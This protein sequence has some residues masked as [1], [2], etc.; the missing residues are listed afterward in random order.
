MHETFLIGVDIGKFNH[1]AAVISSFGDLKVNSFSFTND[2]QGFNKFYET[3]KP[4]LS[5]D[6]LIG[7]E[8]TSHYADNFRLFLLIKKLSVA[9]IN[10]LSTDAFR[11]AA[12]KSTK[13]DKEDARFICQVLM[14]P[15][16]Y[17]RVTLSDYDYTEIRE[18]TRYHHNMQETNTRYKQKLQ[19]DLDLVFPEFNSLFSAPYGPTYM[20][21]LDNFQSAD[22]IAHTDIRRIR[23]AIQPKGSRGRSVSFS[24]EDLKSLAKNS[25]G[26]PN[27]IVEMEI[28]HLITLINDINTIIK[29]VDKKIEEFSIELNSPILSIPGISHFSG[30]SIISEFGDINRFP[31]VNKAI[32]FTGTN[33]IVYQSGGYNA[34]MTRISKKGSK[35]LRK[36]LYQVI[37]PVILNNQVFQDYYNKKRAEGKSHRCAQGHCVRKLVRVIYHLL[38]T[39]ENFDPTKLI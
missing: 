9:M 39:G 30:T 6:H 14:Y 5:Q 35:Y 13:T 10:P 2:K 36:T 34:Q 17:R 7:M 37:E 12:L 38:T 29:D 23:S 25:V 31:D 11:K 24:A 28:K 19:K 20:R 33:P 22:C 32:S 18:L 1:W 21:I 8:D 15:Q 3:V 26:H 16:L 27:A 4:F